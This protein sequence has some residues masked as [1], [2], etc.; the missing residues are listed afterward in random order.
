MS[1]HRKRVNVYEIDRIYGGPEEGGWFYDIITNCVHSVRVNSNRTSGSIRISPTRRKFWDS[2]LE[3][4]LRCRFPNKG[5]RYSVRP[6]GPDY[7]IMV[8]NGRGYDNKHL[9]YQRYE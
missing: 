3:K 8:E 2:K 7:I 5:Y 4:D 1:K 6:K 9:E